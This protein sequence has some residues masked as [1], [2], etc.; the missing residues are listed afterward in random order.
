[1]QQIHVG[2]AI[3][4]RQLRR[5][6]VPRRRHGRLFCHRQDNKDAGRRDAWPLLLIELPV[7]DLLACR[8][9]EGLGSPIVGTPQRRAAATN[10]D[11]SHGVLERLSL[12]VENGILAPVGGRRREQGCPKVHIRRVLMDFREAEL[13]GP[14][15]E[16]VLSPEALVHG[17]GALGRV[18]APIQQVLGDAGADSRGQHPLKELLPFLLVPVAEACKAKLCP[19]PDLRDAV[20]SKAPGQGHDNAPALNFSPGEEPRLLIRLHCRPCRLEVGHLLDGAPGLLGLFPPGALEEVRG[21]HLAIGHR[22]QL[23]SFRCRIASNESWSLHREL[24]QVGAQLLFRLFGTVRQLLPR[25]HGA[26]VLQ[27]QGLSVDLSNHEELLLAQPRGIMPGVGRQVR[28]EVCRDEG[29][30][31]H[32]EAVDVGICNPVLQKVG[33]DLLEP[34]VHGVKLQ[35]V[36]AQEVRPQQRRLVLLAVV[37]LIEVGHVVWSVH[38]WWPAASKELLVLQV[39]RQRAEEHVALARAL[40]SG[41]TAGVPVD[42]LQRVHAIAHL[43]HTLRAGP[44]LDAV[45]ARMVHLNVQHDSNAKPMCL[46]HQGPQQLGIAE[47]GVDG[48]QVGDGKSVVL[49]TRVQENGRQSKDSH[50]QL[51]EVGQPAQD[52]QQVTAVAPLV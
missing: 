19:V 24:L 17:E 14:P 39:S 15:G 18:V 48:C 38:V 30:R 12:T 36:I 41:S 10:A 46:L 25:L 40:G 35:V 47:A 13:H 22:A 16:H 29:R 45:A 28:R 49:A 31:R 37:R 33:V 34:W 26:E 23:C 4:P 32:A 50:T 21:R 20:P 1:M 7:A 5:H 52:T 3:L 11:Q 27:A 43:L 9:A 2:L 8:R 6:G 42:L 44:V 51:P